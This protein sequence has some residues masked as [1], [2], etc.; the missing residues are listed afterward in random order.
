MSECLRGVDTVARL[1]GDEFTVTLTELHQKQDAVAI[2]KKTIFELSKS[3]EIYGQPIYIG[4]S[5]GITSF[6]EDGDELSSMLK[7]ADMAMYEVKNKG[8]N[9]Y[10]FFS[11]EM[12][13]HANH[14]IK[15]EKDLRE[16]FQSNQL[17]LNYQPIINLQTSKICGVEALL[18][19]AHPE[20][21]IV[22]TK[23]YC[24]R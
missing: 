19:W 11:P 17:C 24:Y 2:A 23:N 16:A 3:F 4:S 12:T 13:M 6:P 20:Y 5:I 14:R 21:G 7:N 18:R 10:N 9:A 22:P 8:K 1:G 15:L